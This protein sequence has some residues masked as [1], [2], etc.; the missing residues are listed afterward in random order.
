MS[1]SEGDEIFSGLDVSPKKGGKVNRFDKN[2]PT[3]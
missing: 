2:F 3:T 1:A